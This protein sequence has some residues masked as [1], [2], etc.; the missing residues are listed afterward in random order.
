M[1]ALFPVQSWYA[2]H[3]LDCLTSWIIPPS[4]EFVFKYW[5][6]EHRSMVFYLPDC[7]SPEGPCF[8]WPLDQS[9]KIPNETWDRIDRCTCELW[10]MLSENVWTV[11]TVFNEQKIDLESHG[12]SSGWK[13]SVITQ[14]NLSHWHRPW[15]SPCVLMGYI[16]RSPIQLVVSGKRCILAS[17]LISFCFFNKFRRNML[18]MNYVSTLWTVLAL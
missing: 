2:D 14:T 15:G 7:P 6:R 3:K 9:L 17:L 11:G 4:R 18:F 8:Q 12:V 10:E 1:I 13:L 16:L 5:W